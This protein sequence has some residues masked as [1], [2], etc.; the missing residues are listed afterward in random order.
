MTEDVALLKDV[1]IRRGMI[2]RLRELLFKNRVKWPLTDL[3]LVHP[4]L[5]SRECTAE[6]QQ[7]VLDFINGKNQQEICELVN[8]AVSTVL[9]Y[10]LA[11]GKKDSE[12]VRDTTRWIKQQRLTDGGWHWKPIKLSSADV[13]S[14][15]WMSAGVLATLKITEAAGKNYTNSVLEFLMR[16]WETR[17]WGNNPEVTLVYLGIA[18]LNKNSPMVKKA[19]ELLKMNQLASG[20]WSGYSAKTTRGG[21]F[22]TC[23]ILNALTAV[24]LGLEDTAIVKGLKF[25][26]SRLDKIVNAKWGGVL[27]QGFYGLTSALL[28]LGLID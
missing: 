13:K 1:F 9:T 15:A 22:R 8:G 17:K 26:Q 6:F 10:L 4:V 24:G 2:Y 14:E 12:L 11:G 3:Y 25:A 23:A 5:K 21:V 20:A 18:G 27:I 19:I 7:L 16:D 28:Q